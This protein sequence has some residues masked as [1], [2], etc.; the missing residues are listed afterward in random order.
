M[1]DHVTFAMRGATAYQAFELALAEGG[2]TD[3]APSAGPSSES[4][5]G[6]VTAEGLTADGAL[7][8]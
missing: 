5:T 6:G 3:S 7:R 4:G 2:L 8:T 1:I